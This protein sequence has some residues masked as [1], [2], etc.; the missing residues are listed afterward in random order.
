MMDPLLLQRV[1]QHWPVLTAFA[2]LVLF[3]LVDSLVFHP[4]AQ[5]YHRALR[6]SGTMGAV[7]GAGDAS[8]A[9]PPRVFSLLAENSMPPAEAEAQGQNGQ[10]SAQL[11]Q[12]L[13]QIAGRHGLE[14]V[15][16]EPGVTTPQQGSVQVRAHLK[17]RGRYASLVSFLDELARSGRLYRLERMSFSPDESG[18][19]DI[20]LY[21][22][23]LVLKRLAGR[24]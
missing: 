24:S 11:M 7:F 23:R 9:L 5:R 22:E 16:S 6:A 14:L 18:R 17:L 15:V 20:D 4:L 21:M 2:V 10:L 3:L 19:H 12:D 13:S 1:R 8:R